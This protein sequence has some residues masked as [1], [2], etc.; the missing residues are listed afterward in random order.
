MSDNFIRRL[1]PQSFSPI[2]F[3]PYHPFIFISG[4]SSGFSDSAC[5]SLPKL[6]AP[7]IGLRG[8]SCQVAGDRQFASAPLFGESSSPLSPLRGMW[9]GCWE[10]WYPELEGFRDRSSGCQR[11]GRCVVGV[12]GGH[13]NHSPGGCTID[14]RSRCVGCSPPSPP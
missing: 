6:L 4:C 3:L 13:A 2:P 11:L 9:G 14:L 12:V 5:G 8:L 1:E 10:E 7:S